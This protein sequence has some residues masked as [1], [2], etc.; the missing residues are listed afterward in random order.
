MFERI[1]ISANE[2][3]GKLFDLGFLAESMIFYNEV[4]VILNASSFDGL[5][6]QIGA[7]LFLELVAQGF[8][9]VHFSED[10]VAAITINKGSSYA[11]YDIGLIRSSR[12]DLDSVA[13]DAFVAATGKSGR[14]RR[15]ARRLISQVDVFT[16]PSD[17]IESITQDMLE[18]TYLEAYVRRRLSR[19]HPGV[20]SE[21][22][23]R[24]F[25]KFHSIPGG[26]L[27]LVT[28]LNMTAAS[29]DISEFTDPSSVLALYGASVA[30]MTVW[31]K[32]DSEAVL[33]TRKEDMAQSR[34]NALLRRRSVSAI[35][36]DAFQELVLDDA[37][38]IREAVN[39]HTARFKEI[40][41]VLEKSRKFRGWL[42]GQPT[43][44]D[45]IKAYLRAAT[46]ETWIDRLSTRASRWSIFTTAGIAA[47]V[48]GAGGVGTIGGVAL[49]AFD[50]FMLDKLIGGW[51][52][53]Q[54]VE[55]SLRS[56][57]GD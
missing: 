52:P 57:L 44:S 18:G 42:T 34:F 6:K 25:Y 24:I 19:A 10:M 35:K 38:A 4:H 41:P 56:F 12:T 13:Y 30:E 1:C 49:S 14:G 15:L 3:D 29:F 45:L 16:Y 23:D 31:A 21:I 43:N 5:T 40:L 55:G 11:H 54:F 27:H 33:T 39:T 20:Q 28:N 22:L 53:N 36:L 32:L 37:R 47:D 51:K 7:E 2:P 26:G 48:L 17:M 8:L 50:A 46:A 9:Y